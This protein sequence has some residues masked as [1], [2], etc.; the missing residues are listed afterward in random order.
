MLVWII[1]LVYPSNYN[2][3]NNFHAFFVHKNILKRQK[4]EIAECSFEVDGG[5]GDSDLSYL[6]NVDGDSID[7]DSVL[8]Y[9]SSCRYSSR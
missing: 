8:V 7:E 1:Y 3:E 4:K 2:R 9:L 6:I 5:N